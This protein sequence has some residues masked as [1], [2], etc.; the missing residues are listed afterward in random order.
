MRT[1]IDLK[2]VSFGYR[3]SKA[4]FSNIDLAFPQS[5]FTCVIGHSGSGKTTLLRLIA[6]LEQPG[7]G[8]VLTD[9]DGSPASNA[10]FVFQDYARSLLPWLTVAANVDLA[11]HDQP[12]V[13]R[14]ATRE[15]AL[16]RVGLGGSEKRLPSELSGGMQQR[17]ALARSFVSEPGV[18]LLDEPFGALDMPTKLDLQDM[19]LSLWEEQ[20]FT[21]VHVTHD[22]DEACYLSDSIVVVTRDEGITIVHNPLPR[23]RHKLGTRELPEFLELR[24]QLFMALG[25]A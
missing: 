8:A 23:P 2:G 18:L 13:R 5:S 16:R 19:L 9:G 4:I 14:R 17:V 3:R 1:S 12:S 25:Y 21:A 20:K 22:L 10:Q 6:G 7:G 11:L 24:R 15:H